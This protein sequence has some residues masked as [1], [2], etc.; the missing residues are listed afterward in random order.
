MSR[1]AKSNAREPSTSSPTAAALPTLSTTTPRPG[2]AA[3]SASATLAT[4]ARPFSS[5]NLSASIA[6]ARFK[7]FQV[8]YEI[9]CKNPVLRAVATEIAWK[10]LL[11]LFL[12]KFYAVGDVLWQ[13][14]EQPHEMAFILCGGF[15][16][17][18]MD[19]SAK[20]ES[21]SSN[22]YH[23][24]S[25]GDPV[26]GMSAILAEK[27]VKPGG[28]IAA[29]AVHNNSHLP[30]SIV[31]AKFKSIALTLPSGKYKSILRQLTPETR[32]LVQNLLYE[33]EN[34]LLSALKMHPMTLPPK[35]KHPHATATTRSG[36]KVAPANTVRS[37]PTK[38]QSG[39]NNKKTLSRTAS[40]PAMVP[41]SASA[42]TLDATASWA[43]LQVAK[44]VEYEVNS[45][46]L[47]LHESS[48]M[49]SL[50]GPSSGTPTPSS[51]TKKPF[52]GVDVSS[53]VRLIAKKH[54]Q[55]RLQSI[56]LP[57]PVEAFPPQQKSAG[58]SEGMMDPAILAAFGGK[59]ATHVD[60]V[61][62][63]HVGRLLKPL[64]EST[65][66]YDND[67]DGDLRERGRGNS[68]QRPNTVVSENQ[69]GRR[70][71]VANRAESFR[72]VW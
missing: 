27:M 18:H 13:Q 20:D 25:S 66:L 17:R 24:P 57:N 16:A 15:L 10:N 63:E 2:S 54:T 65:M 61:P 44:P 7:T 53:A 37:S 60:V 55:R 6:N 52:H 46:L 56:K 68:T 12:L 33:T 31:T 69:H 70:V 51:Q 32:T 43:S 42:I 29:L 36:M 4:S 58:G 41:R 49:G 50:H 26:K 40:T 23:Y 38:K 48:S 22:Q 34:T 28:N 3:G 67:V 35:D 30:Y 39:I 19:L 8:Q 21:P 1:S 45:S 9:L 62:K 11:D 59:Q 47:I 64:K 14:G 71:L 5:S 72:D